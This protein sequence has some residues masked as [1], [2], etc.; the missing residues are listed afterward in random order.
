[1]T[2]SQKS[3]EK[4]YIPFIDDEFTPEG[5][6]AS[7]SK[8]I[9]TY[10]Y[11][12][13]D[14]FRKHLGASILGRECH[15]SIYL[16]FRWAGGQDWAGLKDES[17]FEQGARMNRLFTRGHIEES[18]FIEYLRGTGW[19]VYDKDE[20]Q[21]KE[22]GTHPQFRVS[23]YKGHIGGS[24]DGVGIPP[25]KYGYRG[26]M[27]LEFKTSSHKAYLDVRKHGVIKSKPQHYAQMCIYGNHYGLEYGLYMCVDK[28]TDKLHI[29]VVK[30]D[31]AIAK[32]HLGIGEE[33]V[34]ADRLPEAI[35][36]KATDFRCKMCDF[37]RLCF[38]KKSCEKS[39][40]SCKMAVATDGGTW[41][42]R[43]HDAIIPADFIPKGCDKWSPVIND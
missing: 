17:A 14:G 13:D 5:M 16:T 41:T 28:D 43:E 33:I 6:A 37:R 38:E 12:Y 23:G 10:S 39:C 29:E 30:L 25:K 8:D 24:L 26:P 27:L 15:R 9:D 20:S 21:F 7:I 3:P 42:C 40:R 11:T 4:D 32:I 18:R 1:M 22:D 19:T 36:K 31:P 35:S 34:D 2:D